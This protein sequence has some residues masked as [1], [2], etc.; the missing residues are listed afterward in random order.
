[1]PTSPIPSGT[2]PIKPATAPARPAARAAAAAEVAGKAARVP[3][4]TNQAAPVKATPGQAED[5]DIEGIDVLDAAYGATEVDRLIKHTPGAEVGKAGKFAAAA[6]LA[7]ETKEL[8]QALGETPIAMDRVITAMVGIGVNLGE[9]A[10]DTGVLAGIGGVANSIQGF[11]GAVDA[12]KQM[13]ADGANPS[14]ILQALAGATQ[15]LGGI[16]ATLSL[17]CP[18]L[19]PL[20]TGLYLAS[21][22]LFV[23]QLAYDNREWIADKATKMW[24]AIESGVSN[25]FSVFSGTSRDPATRRAT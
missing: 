9:F 17:V 3:A 15:A 5:V 25:L 20:S 19:L 21:G 1:M 6:A 22:A 18:A 12:L 7:L 13:K 10:A 24:G 11:M 2:G 4:D 14:N 16:T 8:V 23:G